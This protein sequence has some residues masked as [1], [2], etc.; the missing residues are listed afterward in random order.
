MSTEI[1]EEYAVVKWD[2]ES[3]LVE[4]VVGSHDSV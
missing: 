1:W 4:S 3:L 2:L